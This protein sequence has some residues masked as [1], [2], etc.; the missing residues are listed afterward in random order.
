MGLFSFIYEV[1]ALKLGW[2]IFPGQEFIGYITLFN[3]SFH[4]EDL[5]F[6][7]ILFALAILSY[8]NYFEENE[9]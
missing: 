5:L 2:W 8:Y 9:K 6:W 7:F 4:I 3:V 1:T